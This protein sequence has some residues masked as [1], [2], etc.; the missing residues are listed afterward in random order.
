M[1][2]L[3]P[4][5]DQQQVV[6]ALAGLLQDRAPLERLKASERFPDTANAEVLGELAGMGI[7]G[8]ALPEDAGG[9]GYGPAEETLCAI[10]MGRFLVTPSA[11][12]A[13][14]A[15]A[16]LADA[17][18]GDEA[19]AL[20][21]GSATACF[22][23]MK[24]K[25][26]YLVDA[27]DAALIVLVQG[28]HITLYPRAAAGSLQ[29]VEGLDWTISLHQTTLDTAQ[30]AVQ[31]S[32]ARLRQAL[33]LI[34]GMQVG[35]TEAVCAMAVDYAKIREQFGQ[36]IGAFQAIKH[37][38]ADLAVAAETARA[39]LLL[40]ALA[41]AADLPEAD[42]LIRA[43]TLVATEAAQASTRE[44]IQIHGGIGY[45]AES[46]AHLFLKRAHLNEWLFGGLWAQREALLRAKAA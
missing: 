3:L 2:H 46:R 9:V 35:L 11:A 30:A 22:A 36:P 45:T 7:Y 31:G 17:G 42:F 37:K 1:I 29:P 14:L 19:A 27:R 44:N 4:D 25:R 32:P 18:R 16:M 33:L 38:C 13:T 28:D 43:A 24:G 21:G 12:A 15:A 23:S 39:Q 34:A 8:L 20:I 5:A 41:G 40:A 10:E 6:D 26:H